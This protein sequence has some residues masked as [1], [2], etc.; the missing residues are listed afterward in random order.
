MIVNAILLLDY[1]P[2]K[3]N[4]E[5]WMTFNECCRRLQQ[6]KE[7][8]FIGTQGWNPSTI[9]VTPQETKAES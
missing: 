3:D 2:I 7:M 8:D 5:N 1:V 4:K 9:T 6:A